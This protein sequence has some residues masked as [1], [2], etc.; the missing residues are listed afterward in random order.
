MR[1]AP[2]ESLTARQAILIAIGLTLFVGLGDYATGIDI[3]FMMLYLAPVAVASWFSG[4]R[5]GVALGAFAAGVAFVTNMHE[6]RPLA[7]TLW[8]EMGS[9]FT[10]A[11]LAVLLDR[12]HQFVLREQQQRRLVVEQLRHAERLNVIGTLAAGVAHELGT[13]LNV[14]S[15]S[16]ELLMAARSPAEIDEMA[17][18]IRSQTERI[19]AIIRHLLDFG[20]RGGSNPT[21][22]DVNDAARASVNLIASTARQRSCTVAFGGSAAPVI[23][24]ANR[25]ELEQVFSNLLLNAIQAMPEGGAAH[26]RV[27]LATRVDRGGDER[28]FAAV[29]VEDAG[30]GISAA[31]LPRIFDPFFTT[32]DV[33][34]GTGLG[35]SVSYGIVQDHGGTIEVDSAVG[36][37][38][39]F[40]VLLP[41]SDT[42]AS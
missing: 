5:A 2:L 38:S 16:A 8:N 36:R 35:L 6:P 40:T 42:H 30:S 25:P 12:L 1:P 19:S 33:G 39:R 41:L 26:L 3:A 13:P 32:K 15:G 28:P 29:T 22:L 37:G 9:F 4:W 21:E 31:D 10:F 11:L 14:I 17:T 7:M 23:V 34:E 27:G 20:R 18:V 24:N